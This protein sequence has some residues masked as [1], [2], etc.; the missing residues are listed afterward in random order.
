[1][2]QFDLR[3]VKEPLGP[4]TVAEI[5]EMARDVLRQEAAKTLG[6]EK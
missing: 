1:M 5:L 6:G 4:E 3:V 2:M